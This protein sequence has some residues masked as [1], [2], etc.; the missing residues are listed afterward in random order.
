MAK[1]QLSN[2]NQKRYFARFYLEAI[3]KLDKDETVINRKAL[4]AAH[5]QSCLFHLVGAYQCFLWEVANTY[6]ENYNAQMSLQALVQRG[7][8]NGKTLAEL[9]RILELEHAKG[10]WLNRMMALWQR[11]SEVDPTQTGEKK[12][13]ANLN[14]I[15]VRTFT[16][17]DEFTQLSDW[18]NNL[19][20]LIEEIRE[21]LV[22]W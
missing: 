6:D 7:R 4:L 10:S 3:E 19:S 17:L 9:E 16:E 13:A 12:E 1:H 18:Y 15:E 5:Q 22:E 21:L 8:E 2:A 20:E 11:I 14:A